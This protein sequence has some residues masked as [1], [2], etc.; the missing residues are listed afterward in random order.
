M[1]DARA[2]PDKLAATSRRYV[3]GEL[4]EE[5]KAN[6]HTVEG[7]RI[8]GE[9][10]VGVR[11]TRGV[12][13]ISLIVVSSIGHQPSAPSFPNHMGVMGRISIRP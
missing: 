1:R 12:A 13:P 3:K 11:V 6:I 5:L 8:K 2:N 7:H 9:C 10:T 4:L